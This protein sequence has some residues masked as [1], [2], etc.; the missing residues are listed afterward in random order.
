MEF[1]KQPYSIIELHREFI[2]IEGKEDHI[3]RMRQDQ[4]NKVSKRK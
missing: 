4:K 3:R 1:D 2:R